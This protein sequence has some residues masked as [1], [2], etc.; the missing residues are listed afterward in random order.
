VP[1]AGIIYND[2]KPTACRAAIELQDTLLSNGWQVAMATGG[3]GILGYSEPDRPV[4]HTSIESLVPP[5]FDDAMSFAVV[6]GGDGTV[7]AAF[8][9]VAPWG[10]P[11]LAVIRVIWAFSPKYT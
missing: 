7:L 1:K 5:G 6:L 10:I 9:Q 4:C 8:R 2:I 3:Q 11:L